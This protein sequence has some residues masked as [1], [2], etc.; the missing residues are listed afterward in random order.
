[1]KNILHAILYTHALTGYVQAPF[2][3]NNI[4]AAADIKV[5]TL[6]ALVKNMTALGQILQLTLNSTAYDAY[7]AV[8]NG[9]KSDGCKWVGIYISCCMRA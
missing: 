4:T 1:M 8:T 7:L 9:V 2:V 5:Q 3:P 6:C